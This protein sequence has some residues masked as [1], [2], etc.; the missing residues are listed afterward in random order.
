MRK[1]GFKGNLSS[2]DEERF[3]DTILLDAL[4]KG[5]SAGM[6]VFDDPDYV[7]PFLNQALSLLASS[8]ASS[9]YV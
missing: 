6:I 5:G 8:S 3:L 4:E 2:Q 9:T 7:I 1:R